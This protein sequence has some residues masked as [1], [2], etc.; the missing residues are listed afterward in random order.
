LVSSL[1]YDE[2][3]VLEVKWKIAEQAGIRLLVKREDLN[4]PFI[5]GNK[6]WKLK[7]N[8]EEAK[9]EKKD[10]LLTFGGAFSN[11]I[12]ATAA[13]AHELG[14]R[15]MGVIRG[16][17]TLPLNSTLTFVKSQGMKLHYVSREEYRKKEEEDF[18]GR[19]R[20]QFGNFY[21]IPEGGTNELAVRGCAEFGS[22]LLREISFD[23]VCLPVGTGGTMAGVISGMKGQKQIVGISVLK[24]GEFLNSEIRNLLKAE[25]THYENW[26]LLTSYH[27]GGYAKVTKELTDFIDQMWQDHHLPLDHVYSAKLF[28]ALKEEINRGSFERGSTVLALHTGGLQG[29][30]I[31]F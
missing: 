9:L 5:S 6:W 29:S 11:H 15:S 10:T 1:K 7:Y 30:K 18:I 22:K 14:L 13:A 27:H 17:E 26:R 21:L 24:N 31:N 19:L 12:Y 3:P 2:T 16:E 8:L 25:T 23:H 28:W 20:T 4:H